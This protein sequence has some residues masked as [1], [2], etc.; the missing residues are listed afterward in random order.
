MKDINQMACFNSTTHLQWDRNRRFLCSTIVR[1]SWRRSVEKICQAVLWLIMRPDQANSAAP[2][3]LNSNRPAENLLPNYTHTHT[4][5][6][7]PSTKH[8]INPPPPLKDTRT[9]VQLRTIGIRD[10]PAWVWPSYFQRITAKITERT[11]YIWSMCSHH[12]N[13]SGLLSDISIE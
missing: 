7:A 6:R 11:E 12:S 13:T 8:V 9:F 10:Y 2:Y 5:E 3:P 4:Q 1:L